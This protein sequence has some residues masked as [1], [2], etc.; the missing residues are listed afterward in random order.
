[1]TVSPLPERDNIIDAVAGEVRAELGRARI[2]VSHLPRLLGNSYAYWYR[3]ASGETPIDVNDLYLLAGLLGTTPAGLLG[4]YANSPGPDGPD[5]GGEWAPS[6]SNRRPTD[7][8]VAGL[9][10]VVILPSR[11]V[12]RLTLVETAA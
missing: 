8:K 3:R 11:A 6:G 9:A 2:R 1:M 4:D 7:Y 10:P 5:G 12:R